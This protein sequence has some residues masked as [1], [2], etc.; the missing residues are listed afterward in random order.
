M[1]QRNLVTGINRKQHNSAKA[2]EPGK[3]SKVSI[4]LV[5]L[6]QLREDSCLQLIT[7]ST[8]QDMVW[9]SSDHLLCSEIF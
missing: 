1:I 7:Y 6:C 3:M 2:F 8:R 9:C 5:A 4:P